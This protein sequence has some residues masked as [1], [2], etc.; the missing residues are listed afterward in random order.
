MNR[1]ESDR[2]QTP[3]QGGSRELHGER[4]EEEERKRRRRSEGGEGGGRKEEGRGRPE[5]HC[6]CFWPSLPTHLD[7]RPSVKCLIY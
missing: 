6:T 2:T 7:Y 4:E 5:A 1:R 3:A